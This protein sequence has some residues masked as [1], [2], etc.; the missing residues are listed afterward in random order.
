M[1]AIAK[2]ATDRAAAAKTQ[3]GANRLRKAQAEG[4]L[5]NAQPLSQIDADAMVRDR[6][7]LDEAEMMELRDSIVSTGCAYPSRSAYLAHCVTM[8][9]ATGCC[10]GITD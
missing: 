10:R 3:A 9:C 2:V 6:S 8:A 7:C 1:A 5:M 4:L